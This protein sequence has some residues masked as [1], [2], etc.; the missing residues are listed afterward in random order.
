MLLILAIRR[1]LSADDSSAWSN[2]EEA[3]WLALNHAA[4]DRDHEQAAWAALRKEAIDRTGASRPIAAELRQAIDGL[5]NNASNDR[6]AGGALTALAA[7]DS[8][9]RCPLA[10]GSVWDCF[11]GLVAGGSTPLDCFLGQVARLVAGNVFFNNG[12]NTPQNH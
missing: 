4:A 12:E 8:G 2:L 5:S 3:T 6:A 10:W 7:L 9:R 11:L 1:V